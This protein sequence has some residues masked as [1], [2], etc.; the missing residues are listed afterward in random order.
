MILSTQYCILIDSFTPHHLFQFT[1]IG[2]NVLLF[3]GVNFL[4]KEIIVKESI[5]DYCERDSLLLIVFQGLFRALSYS[6]CM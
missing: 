2:E 3:D 1:R 6:D 4:R 5:K